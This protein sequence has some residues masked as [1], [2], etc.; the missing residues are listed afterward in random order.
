MT[1]FHIETYGSNSNFADAEYMAG[2]LKQAKFELKEKS[3]EADIVIFNVNLAESSKSAYI[4]RLEEIKNNYPYKFI[5]ITGCVSRS[6]QEK[7]TKFSLLGTRNI[8]RI[9]EVVEE[10]LNENVVKIFETSEMP[11]LN[12]PKIKRNP[13]V[14]I[15][16]INRGCQGVCMCPKNKNVGAGETFQL[17]QS[18]PL[19]DIVD[20]AEKAVR[21]GVKEIL[22]T[23]QDTLCYGLDIGTTLPALLQELIKIPGNFKIRIDQG[24]PIHLKTIK[25]DLFPLLAHEKIFRFLH[26]PIQTGSNAVLKHMHERNTAEEY[27][28]YVTELKHLYPELTLV[29]DIIVGYP[30]EK[31]E[32][33]AATQKL[34][35]EISPDI[36]NLSSFLPKTKK[37]A[38]KIKLSSLSAEVVTHR[39]KI[40]TDLFHNIS[41]LQ[42]ERWIGWE[43]EIIISE[44]VKESDEGN[45]EGNKNKIPRWIG[46]NLSYKPVLVEGNFKLGDIVKARIERVTVL[47]LRGKVI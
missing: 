34:L 33:F 6:E 3:E 44:K 4:N 21:D 27:A 37:T 42:N 41:L 5:I 28:G 1:S 38:A 39:L 17:F 16:P 12:L 30:T 19:K 15:I 10:A 22:L 7:L 47:D 8:H 11:P 23:S 32:D 31:D 35:R 18:Y 46:R 43:G 13:F 9:V 45:D 24:N 26:I 36:I 29:T 14:E 25:R 2:L 20:V 40:V